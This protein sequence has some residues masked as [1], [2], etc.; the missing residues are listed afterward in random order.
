VEATPVVALV[1]VPAEAPVGGLV[2][3][4]GAGPEEAVAAVAAAMA[5]AVEGIDLNRLDK[6][7]H[8]LTLQR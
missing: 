3:V 2:V 1:G 7:N 5:A 8:T 4:P 6:L